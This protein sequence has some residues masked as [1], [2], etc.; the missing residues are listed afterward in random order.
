MCID[1]ARG[2]PGHGLTQLVDDRLSCEPQLNITGVGSLAARHEVSRQPREI[3]K[4]EQGQP[5]PATVASLDV[6]AASIVRAVAGDH[7]G[8]AVSRMC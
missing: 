6:F 7:T 1:Q 5:S 4:V 3:Q 8:T 2:E